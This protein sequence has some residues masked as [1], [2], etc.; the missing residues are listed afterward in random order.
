MRRFSFVV[1]GCAVGCALLMF[2][3]TA[4]TVAPLRIYSIDVE[5]GQSTLIVDALGES[6]LVDTGWPGFN[7][8]DANR[9]VAAAQAA[10]IKQI[11][12]LE[13]THY[14]TDHV[15]G[16]PQLA[17]LMKIGTFVD[18]GVNTEDV[19]PTKDGYAAYM[20]VVGD[21]KHLIVKPG[22]K[23]PFK[24]M[25]VQVLTA[26]GEQ[27][28]S[29]LPGAGQPNPLCAT[30]PLAPADATENAQ[31]VGILVTVGKFRFLDLGDLVKIKERGLVC[32]DNLIGTVDVFLVSHHGLFQSNSKV[33]VDALHPRVAI[34]NNGAHK[35][36][37]PEAW[38]TVHDSP[39][40]Q[41]LWQLHY[42]VEGAEAHNVAEKFIANPDEK[43]DT[44]SYIEVMAQRNGNFTVVN[45]RNKFEKTY[46]K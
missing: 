12:Y 1:A 44:G 32:P 43:N 10:G 37:S 30:E 35:G 21:N 9:I 25:D 29:A 8:R 38:Q 18:H 17:A 31:S 41:D 14:H 19:S 26:A 22:D 27:I 40:L 7:S 13:I 45:S 6:L 33:M 5:G 39:G 28:K 11:D 46:T 42:S 2:C 16:V 20:K 36:G 15:G 3:A 34:M 23:I 24:G 4:A